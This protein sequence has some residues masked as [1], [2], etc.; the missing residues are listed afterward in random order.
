MPSSL[1]RS[2][3]RRALAAFVRDRRARIHPDE[4]GLATGE[5]RRTPGLRREE[6]AL[7][8]HVGVTWY[9]W[10]E[11]GRDIQVSADFLE[12]LSRAFRLDATER[13]HLYT[14]ALH[15]PPPHMKTAVQA[16][17]AVLQATLDGFANPTYIRTPRWD[18]VAW[19]A[20]ASELFGDYGLLLPSQRNILRLVF[21]DPSYRVMMVDWDTD[22]RRLLAKFRVD[23]GRGE[24]DPDFESLVQELCEMS[25]EFNQW[26]PRQD[27]SGRGEG[28]KRLRHPVLGVHEFQHASFIVEGAPDLRMIIHTPITDQL[29]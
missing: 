5:R 7:L 21:T 29:P 19:N 25:A 17:S 10:F 23:Y 2:D 1:Q 6:V 4:V 3:S 13:S 27:V 11:Q 14:L 28:I 9:T 24:G 8:A 18:V 26:W 22:A 16:V 12:R 20:A 15:R